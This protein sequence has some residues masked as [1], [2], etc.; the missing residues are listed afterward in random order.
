MATVAVAGV[1]A[2]SAFAVPP[3]PD[4]S[5]S[6]NTSQTSAANHAV[7]LK[8]DAN[9]HVSEFSIDWK[10]KCKRKGISW[11]AGTTITPGPD[12]L[13]MNGEVFGDDGGYS[14]KASPKIKGKVTISLRGQ[15]TDNDNANG[16]WNAKVVV[17]KKNK[18]G[19]F[20]KHDKCKAS[21]TWSATRNQ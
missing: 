5:F 7:D 3:P 1:T 11:T 14:S 6:G 19:K 16:T 13:A 18:K 15:F 8:T 9:G 12:G 21:I 10:A 4:G 2:A 17:F 20:K